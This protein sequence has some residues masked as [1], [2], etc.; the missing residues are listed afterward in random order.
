[1]KNTILILL[2]SLPFFAGAQTTFA[3]PG[4]EWYHNQL[5]GVYHCYY[6]GDTVIN[7]IAS[8]IIIRQALTRDP[9]YSQGLHVH[10]LTA[11]YVYNNT[12]TVFI[13][14]RYFSR[15]TP[16]YIFNV[17]DDDTIHLPVIPLD[18][19][20]LTF[21][22]SDSTFSVYVDSV[23]MKLYD[24]TMLKTVYT[25]PLGN[26]DSNYV[27]RYCDYYD[28]IGVYAERIGGLKTGFIPTGLPA[29][30]LLSESVQPAGYLRCYDDPSISIKLTTDICGIPPVAVPELSR[31]N[32]ISLSPNPVH[33]ILKLE[34]A[35]AAGNI[36]ITNAIGQC[37]YNRQCS[38]TVTQINLTGFAPGV[39]YLHLD[40][41]TVRKFIKE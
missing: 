16:L 35:A 13:Y 11:I 20:D 9:Y 24:T 34:T 17:N 2:L 32:K 18:A 14:N 28:T 38:A 15:F 12:D 30:Q 25:H 19:A 21:S 41:G 5:F 22:Y 37:V 26:P 40:G 1:M 23:R 7:N 4:S 10:D 33:D 3:P 8:R 6:A 27:Y 39:Y 29:V 31:K 36:S